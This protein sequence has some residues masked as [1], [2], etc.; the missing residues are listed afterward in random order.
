MSPTRGFATFTLIEMLVVV[1]IIG[2]TLTLV[3]VSFQRDDKRVLSDEAQRVGLLLEHAR[4]EAVASSQ[5]LAWEANAKGYRF[6]VAEGPDSWS[7]LSR[8]DVFHPRLWASGVTFGGLRVMQGSEPAY[9]S[10]LEFSPSGFNK[11][12]QMTLAAGDT[13]A[14]IS[15]DALGRIQL[16]I[17]EREKSAYQFGG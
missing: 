2:I 5:M 4:D 3:V 12:F 9:S 14:L 8:D 13:Y 15:G 6:A 10:H 7:E 17:S 16:K 1:V 11:P